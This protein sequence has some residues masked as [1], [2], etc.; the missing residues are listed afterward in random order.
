MMIPAV[1]LLAGSY[2]PL[3]VALSVVI[4]VAASYAALDLAGRVTAS[5]RWSFAAW[6]ICGSIAMGI[7]IWSMHF[8]GMLAFSLPVPVSYYWPGVLE[9]FIVAVLA[10]TLALYVVSRKKMSSARAVGSGVAM[11]C[12]IAALHYMDM[13]AMRMGA[14]CR[15]NP[16]LA[17]LSVAF[18]IAFSYSAL[19]LAFYFRAAQEL[20]G[21]KIGSALVMAA[22][23]A[24]HYTGMAA[25]TF[26]ASGI[27]QDLSHSVSV[28]S[29]GCLVVI[30]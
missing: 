6:L 13:M 7:G 27:E 21:Q 29:L 18:A 15:F 24:M 28:P 25:A 5:K 16:L 14:E 3:V 2:D 17:G 26:T 30:L 12:G 11:G 19:R 10:A 20:P 9:S 8:A 1:T 4:A 22:I 23:C